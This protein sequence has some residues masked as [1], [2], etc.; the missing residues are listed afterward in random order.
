MGRACPIPC[1]GTPETQ[2]KFAERW[3]RRLG[4]EE[5]LCVQQRTRMQCNVRAA[6]SSV[7]GET[8]SAMPL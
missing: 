4:V 5:R 2:D 7:I 3:N 1:S 6:V 8:V